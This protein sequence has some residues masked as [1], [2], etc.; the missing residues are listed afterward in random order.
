MPPK[1][2]MPIAAVVVLV[3]V[4]AVFAWDADR[5]DVIADGVRIGP[6]DVSG[7]SRDE[8]RVRV[9]ERLLEPL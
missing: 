3:G 9:Q 1:L 2:I 7:L 5:S 4:V 8:A 6:V